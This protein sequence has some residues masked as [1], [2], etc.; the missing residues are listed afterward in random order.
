LLE[1]DG[2]CGCAALL[3]ARRVVVNEAGDR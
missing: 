2:L 3:Q 1:H